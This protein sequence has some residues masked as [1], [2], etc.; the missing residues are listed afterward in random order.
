MAMKTSPWRL[1][2]LPALA[3]V[4]ACSSERPDFGTDAAEG[5]QSSNVDET[6]LQVGE[7]DT[8][9]S[10]GGT[11]VVSPAAS[12]ELGEV[13]TTEGDGA[14][15]AS[16]GGGD[17]S[18]GESNAS[19]DGTNA[20]GEPGQETMGAG[21]ENGGAGGGPSTSTPALL[22]LGEACSAPSECASNFCVD[23]VCC[24][25][26]CADVCGACNVAG[27]E[28]TCTLVSQD[29]ACGSPQCPADTECRSYVASDASNCAAVGQ[30]A[31]TASCSN[32]DTASGTPCQNGEGTCDGAGQ[33]VV[34]D[35]LTLGQTCT[36]NE[37]CGSDSCAATANGTS[38]CCN[39]ACDGV[40]ETCG[41][42]G[43]CDEAPADDARCQ[44]I[45]CAADTACAD[46]PAALTTDRCSAFGQCVTEA[47]HCV[48]SYADTST[49]CGTGMF[50]D[51]AGTCAAACS[52]GETWCSDSCANLMTDDLNCGMCGK[53]CPGTSSCVSGSCEC[54]GSGELLCSSSCIDVESDVSNCG[55]CGNA[56]SPP[57]EAGSSAICEDGKCGA[58]GAY[59]QDCCGTSCGSGFVCAAGTCDCQVGNHYCSSGNAA[60]SCA[61]DQDINNCGPTCAD[62]NQPNA[63]PACVNDACANTCP[64]GIVTLCPAGSNG[65]P[66]CGDWNFESN[67][68]E[69]WAYD[70]ASSEPSFAPGG[71]SVLVGNEARYGSY[72]LAVPFDS[73][74]VDYGRVIVRVPL[75]SSGQAVDVTGKTISAYVRFVTAAGSPALVDSQGAN[76]I[77]LYSGPNNPRG[78][79]SGFQVNKTTGGDSSAGSWFRASL[80]VDAGFVL[81]PDI[82]PAATHVGFSF[83]AYPWKGTIYIDRV[84]IK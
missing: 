73:T 20:T 84:E 70:T 56:C 44:A 27:S 77:Y 13:A 15:S 55:S 80:S 29:D 61:D 48:A 28:G 43:F 79:G 78:G 14:E 34:P 19:I 30:C 10:D 53:V 37:E 31:A 2:F 32:Q 8:E 26:A 54:T 81:A 9:A 76:A 71:A 4:A 50:C 46:Y 64:A 38:V 17:G 23:G 47:A 22:A 5:S 72:S 69:G 21:A 39:E 24:G 67:D 63:Q 33:C 65:K 60:G 7:S 83:S 49:S 16:I 66:S 18:D 35:K 57:S 74:S 45:T 11:G 1:A 3:V 59:S 42:D 68:V 40:C 52:G 36:S 6:D 62:C 25:S 12:S 41:A 82:P 75:C 51:G 58:C